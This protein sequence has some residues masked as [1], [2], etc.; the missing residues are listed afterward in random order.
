[1]NS[2]HIRWL[3][4]LTEH[5]VCLL[6]VVVVCLRTAG[7]VTGAGCPAP[8]SAADGHGRAV[9]QGRQQQ[10]PAA[11]CVVTLYVSFRSLC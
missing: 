7:H 1:M 10:H 5:V 4:V 6:V 2:T 3:P 8:C 11:K 9:K